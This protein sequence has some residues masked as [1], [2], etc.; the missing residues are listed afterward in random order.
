MNHFL[1]RS[2][3]L[4]SAPCRFHRFF[5]NSRLFGTFVV[6]IAFSFSACQRQTSSP[7]L[8]PI[9]V[10][11]AKPVDREVVTY[12]EFTGNTAAVNSVDIRARVSGYLDKVNFT[13]GSIV[14]AGDLL[15]VI[16]P[17]PY[18]AALDQAQA[19]LEQAKAQYDLAQSNF[20]RSEDL[21]QRG[22]ISPQDYQ[23]TLASKEQANAGVLSNQAALATA[24]LNME[25]TEI[26]SPIDGRT[27][28]Y[29]FTIGNLI[30]AGDT[31]SSGTLTSII[32]VDP[33]YVYF[34]VEER[35]MLAYQE[36]MRSGKI[37]RTADSKVVVEM[38][39]ANEEG[40]PHKGYVDFVDNKVDPSSGTIRTR[41]VFP[42]KDEIIRPGLFARVRLPSGPQFKA[43]LISDLAIGY[44]QGQ[45]IVYVVGADDVAT[46]KSVQ[47]GAL[48]DGLRVIEKGISAD[49]KIVVNGI[50]HLRPGTK[51]A[52]KDGNMA[53]FAGGLRRQV[54][55]APP[56]EMQKTEK[57]PAS[58]PQAKQ[59]A[60]KS[61]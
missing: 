43:L 54:S 23:T 5:N 17:R 57:Q 29:G 52:A 59:S 15:F 24:K 7:S 11:V 55:T 31:S 14:K 49:D 61:E 51:V 21:K 53:D 4:Y 26:R 28:T 25:F 1:S 27:S 12:V 33:A 44:D 20:T 10:T 30:A 56:E 32:S 3:K 42:N 39:L 60:G 13:E 2:D 16:D 36:A 48:S 46:A 41:G 58:T 40:Y 9:S 19:N 47:L 8:P 35:A 38:Q 45:P 18:Q 34:N 22:V 37:T 50:I 6:L